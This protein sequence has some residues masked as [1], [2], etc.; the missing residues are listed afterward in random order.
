MQSPRTGNNC[1]IVCYTVFMT[2]YSKWIPS[3]LRSLVATLFVHTIAMLVTGCDDDIASATDAKQPPVANLVPSTPPLPVKTLANGQYDPSEFELRWEI[4]GTIA[5]P[6][7]ANFRFAS[8]DWTSVIY[9]TIERPFLKVHHAGFDAKTTTVDVPTKVDPNS[10]DARDFG[11]PFS[12]IG[13]DAT[14]LMSI[15]TGGT[16]ALVTYPVGPMNPVIVHRDKA[17]DPLGPNKQVLFLA[18]SPDGK[19]LAYGLGGWNESVANTVVIDGKTFDLP[20]SPSLPGDRHHLDW[21][22]NDGIPRGVFFSPDSKRSLAITGTR[23]LLD[24]EVVARGRVIEHLFAWSSDSKR[25]AYVSAFDADNVAVFVDGKP[26]KAYPHIMTGSL[27]FKPNSQEV[28]YIASDVGPSG[29]FFVVDGDKEGKR[30][31]YIEPSTWVLADGQVVYNAGLSKPS[32]DRKEPVHE[33]GSNPTFKF[34]RPGHVINGEERQHM[35]ADAA[36]DSK[37]R[38]AVVE[39]GRRGWGGHRGVG[40]K[41]QDQ[42]SEDYSVVRF[43]GFSPNGTHY[44]YVGSTANQGGACL[45]NS[46]ITVD[47]VAFPELMAELSEKLGWDMHNSALMLLRWETDTTLTVVLHRAQ[48]R[49]AK[50][51]KRLRLTIV[52]RVRKAQ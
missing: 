28:V 18:Q 30:Y 7:N 2:A 29:P 10:S 48:T 45:D 24:G 50:E 6:K 51:L 31:P 12:V 52:P 21:Q 25:L 16:M 14:Q 44:A 20:V 11:V 42:S 43:L 9:T 37:G 3:F 38:V 49:E 33:R 27:R 22:R 26:G 8:R 15:S 41:Y 46:T 32:E 13:H 40:V 5:L 1:P 17:T 39:H 34:S 4:T 19:R 35:I 36:V 23:I 47:G